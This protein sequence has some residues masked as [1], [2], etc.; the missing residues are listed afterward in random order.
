MAPPIE[1]QLTK[2]VRAPPLGLAACRQLSGS[3]FASTKD[4]L[5]P[6]VKW[7]ANQWPSAV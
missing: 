3:Q 5:W 7:W 6:I 4:N 2:N 1:A